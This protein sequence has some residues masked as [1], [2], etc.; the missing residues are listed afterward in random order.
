MPFD[1]ASS[2]L[3]IRERGDGICGAWS[4]FASQQKTFFVVSVRVPRLNLPASKRCWLLGNSV[5]EWVCPRYQGKER[6]KKKKKLQGADVLTQCAPLW[7]PF[8]LETETLNWFVHADILIP[9]FFSSSSI[10]CNY[11]DYLKRGQI[12]PL[13]TCKSISSCLIG[14]AKLAP[15]SPRLC[16]QRLKSSSDS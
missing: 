7:V 2:C 6:K 3:F 5:S 15:S 10:H 16:T 4:S 8:L 9:V 13:V 14:L 12:V 11:L 1:G